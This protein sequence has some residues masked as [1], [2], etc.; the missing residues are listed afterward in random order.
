MFFLSIA[1]FDIKNRTGQQWTLE[2]IEDALKGEMTRVKEMMSLMPASITDSMNYV[3]NEIIDYY[4]SSLVSIIIVRA[5]FVS[6][7]LGL[8]CHITERGL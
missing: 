4:T 6:F 5:F 3:V 8:L 2:K 7:L 1:K